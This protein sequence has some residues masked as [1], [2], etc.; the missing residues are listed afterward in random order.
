M[1]EEN[2][3][4][5][6]E[7]VVDNSNQPED[8]AESLQKQIDEAEAEDVE[9]EGQEETPEEDN[10]E[11]EKAKRKRPNGLRRKV[12]KLE[13]KLAEYEAKFN[14]SNSVAEVEKEP[15]LEDFSD[16]D[17]FYKALAKYEAKQLVRQELKQK[18]LNERA[19]QSL[20]L[21][22]QKVSEIRKEL[23]DYDDVVSEYDDVPVRQ[24]ILNVMQESDIGPKIAYHLA[25]NPELLSAINNDKVSALQIAKQLGIIEAQ[26]SAN[27]QTQ[28]PVARVTKSPA[29]ITP[30]K[31][32]APST[33][34]LSALDTDAFIKFR[35]SQNKK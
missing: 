14:Q 10:A 24:E 5:A 32:S 4:I 22:N 35:N 2:M 17:S 33:V 9:A 27:L 1:T 13:A 26:L 16:Y 7:N 18:E 3:S 12:A 30:V 11:G 28:K 23:P 34:D 31:R 6:A 20:N 15:T 19:T 21:W 29:P 8:D 25:K